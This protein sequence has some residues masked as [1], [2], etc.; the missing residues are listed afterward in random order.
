MSAIDPRFIRWVRLTD[1][2]ARLCLRAMRTRTPP[3]DRLR[4]VAAE[5]STMS[6]LASTLRPDELPASRHPSR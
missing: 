4:R 5:L 2:Y 1:I 3:S 6:E